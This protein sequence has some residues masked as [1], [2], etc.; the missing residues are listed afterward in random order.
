MYILTEENQIINTENYRIGFEGNKLNAYSLFLDER[1][2]GQK[3]LIGRFEGEAEAETALKDIFNAIYQENKIWSAAEYKDEK[4]DTPLDDTPLDDTPLDDTPLDDTPL[5]DTPMSDWPKWEQ[6]VGEIIVEMY[7]IRDP[8]GQMLFKPRD[9]KDYY[10]R[11]RSM[12]PENN[13]ISATISRKLADLL[14]REVLE[15]P[16]YSQY[17]IV[18]GELLFLHLKLRVANK[19]ILESNKELLESKQKITELEKQ[20]D[21]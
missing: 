10:P 1:K 19:E 21:N 16:T 4:E 15:K 14:S 20:L 18:E 3:V 9:L 8:S 13:S 6:D 2:A 11:L 17:R 12:W 7:E 5:D